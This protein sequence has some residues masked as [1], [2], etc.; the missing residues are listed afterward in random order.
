MDI[1]GMVPKYFSMRRGAIL[2]CIIGQLSATLILHLETDL[3][4]YYNST[5]AFPHSSRHVPHRLI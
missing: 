2:V 5:M 3:P 4:R 1:A